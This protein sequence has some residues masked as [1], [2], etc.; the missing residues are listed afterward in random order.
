MTPPLTVAAVQS[1][2]VTG[3]VVENLARAEYLLAQVPE[4][5]LVVF[6]ELSLTGYD[7]DLLKNDPRAWFRPGDERLDPIREAVAARGACVVLGAPVEVKGRRHIASLV[8][9]GIGPDVVAP[10]TY[11]H[12]AENDLVEPGAGPVVLAVAD[13]KIA[14]AVCFDTS[15]PEHAGAAGTAGAQVYVA[16]VLYTAGEERKMADRM[17]ARARD[18]GMWS[19]AANLGGHPVGERSSG[20]TGVWAPDGTLRAGATGRDE[21]IVIEILHAQTGPA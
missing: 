1:V 9:T 19:V 11:L 13:W 8:L 4:A 5:D 3:D 18:N 12:G 17:A 6:P 10:K 2:P 14:L 21:E 15:V 7:L 20:G 16:S